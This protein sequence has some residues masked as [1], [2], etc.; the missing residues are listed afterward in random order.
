M[1]DLKATCRN[2]IIFSSSLSGDNTSDGRDAYW[3]SAGGGTWNVAAGEISRACG[4]TYEDAHAAL[5]FAGRKYYGF[6]WSY[7]FWPQQDDDEFIYDVTDIVTMA[8]EA[9]PSVIVA[10]A[11][12]IMVEVSRERA[13]QG[14]KRNRNSF[15]TAEHLRDNWQEMN[16]Y[17]I[18]TPFDKAVDRLAQD[19][20][21]SWD[22]YQATCRPEESGEA[23]WSAWDI[24]NHR[25]FF[26]LH[27]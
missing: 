19:L 14:W 18:P 11:V 24:P 10:P 2:F 20:W 4:C 23:D 15:E 9:A 25:P 13:Y 22:E 7:G 3:V 6:D 17:R 12:D 5:D 16:G 21:K 26:D 27:H 8:L 1:K